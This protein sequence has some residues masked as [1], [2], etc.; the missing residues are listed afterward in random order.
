MTTNSAAHDSVAA[1][2]SSP[3]DSG[4]AGTTLS[5]RGLLGSVAAGA[6]VAALGAVAGAGVTR[7]ATHSEVAAALHSTKTGT[8]VISCH[9]A[10][11][12]G[13]TTPATSHLRALAFML[14]PEVQREDLQ[15]LMRLLTADI[16]ALTSGAAPVADSEPH[17]ALVP[18]RLTITVAVGA[19]F[20]A[21]VNPAAVPGWLGPLPAFKKDRLAPEFNGGDL[22][23]QLTADDQVTVS[24][25]ARVLT[26]TVRSF[27]TPHWIQDGFRRTRG[28]EPDGTTM[29]N[30]MGQVD[31][32]F[33]PEP[34]D[35]DF[36]SL[37][38]LD[39][40]AGWLAG[41]TC[42]VLRRIRMELDTWDEVDR[43]GRE[44][45]IGRTL[46]TGAPLTGGSEKDPGD[47]TAVN[48]LK[49]PVIHAAAHIRRAHST[50]PA[51]RIFRRSYNYDAG[52]EQG[53]LFMCYQRDPR[54]Q[55]IPIQQRLDDLDM[56]NQWVTHTGS[57]VFAVLPGWQPGGMLA[58][59]LFEL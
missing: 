53:L 36:S 57:A 42:Q 50:D 11:Q 13:V 12:A 47:F 32:S 20:V 38:W 58:Q 30:L 10:H 25:A 27:T 17:L 34:T 8:D 49:L 14:R 1:S 41:G 26:R 16:E 23:L 18:A 45:T 31:G 9:G 19:E 5:R 39:A 2:E 33:N 3:V 44:A 37:V 7:A 24:H 54:K 29:R 52:S 59:A 21:R 46:A 48:E 51:E 15:R 40:S 43:P 22:L 56:L 55:F 35:P 28:S 6:G 4:A